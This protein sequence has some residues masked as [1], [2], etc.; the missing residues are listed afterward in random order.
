M[1]L[2]APAPQ[3]R[4]TYIREAAKMVDFLVDQ[5]IELERSPYWP[6]YYDEKP[7]G[8]EPG[9]TVVA[10]LFDLGEWKHKLRENKSRCRSSSTKPW[11]C[12]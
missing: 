9:R 11:C 5:G 10:K 7:G 1:I 4:A 12:H 8:C 3:R 6:D 2:P